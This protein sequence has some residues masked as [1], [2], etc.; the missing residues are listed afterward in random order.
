M[1]KKNIEILEELKTYQK[2]LFSDLEVKD[3]KRKFVKHGFVKIS[4]LVDSETKK[5][6]CSEVKALAS[7]FSERRDLVLKTTGN[8]PRHLNIVRSQYISEKGGLIPTLS[9]SPEFTKTL[10]LIAGEKFYPAPEADEEFVI[11]EQTKAG[12]THGWHWGNFAYALIWVVQTPPVEFGGMLQCVPHTYWNKVDPQVNQS[13]CDNSIE[14]HRLETGD[15]YLL[16]TD[17]TL[18]RTVPLAG[19]GE[20]R[21][22]LNMTWGNLSDKT[23]IMSFDDRW[24]DNVNA[25]EAK[26]TNGQC[27]I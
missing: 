4:N 24:W 3:M 13:L 16:R 19:D 9:R 7:D 14:T 11:T 23:K 2:E 8:T 6:I 10:E 18:H 17:T 21:V 26:L 22:I 20:V 1:C 15:I 27:S 5:N 12:D 25:K